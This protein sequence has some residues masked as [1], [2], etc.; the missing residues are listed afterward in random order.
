MVSAAGDVPFNASSFGATLPPWSAAH[1]Y[2]N[3]YGPK[4]PTTATGASAISGQ[5]QTWDQILLHLVPT[6]II[7]AMAT[8]DVLQIVIFS[9]VFAIGL[10]MLGE[11]GKPMVA[12][13]EA[14]AERRT[15]E[16]ARIF[17]TLRAAAHQAD[18][19][20]IEVHAG[21]GLDFTTARR[22][23]AIPQVRE[24][25][26]G[27]FL[28]GEAIFTGLAPAIAAMRAVID[29]GRAAFDHRHRL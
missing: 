25:N 17:E 6:S 23:A 14:L 9:M 20:G 19:S 29:E 27:H 15:D 11:K 12:W 2:V 1:A 8:G 22:I 5:A 26:I 4:S 3:L 18:E 13:C 16:A 28:I 7:E 24:L 21:H 10:G